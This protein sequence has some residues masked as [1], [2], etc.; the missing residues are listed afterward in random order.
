MCYYS[1]QEMQQ[2]TLDDFGVNQLLRKKFR[3]SQQQYI[4]LWKSRHRTYNP[5][6]IISMIDMLLLGRKEA[7]E[8]KRGRRDKTQG[9]SQSVHSPC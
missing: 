9:E 8:G 3:V 4:A 2:D 5:V 7:A 6:S 1:M